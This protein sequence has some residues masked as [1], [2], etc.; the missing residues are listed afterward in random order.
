MGWLEMLAHTH[1]RLTRNVGVYVFS[2]F[3]QSTRHHGDTECKLR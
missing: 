3:R 2:W 1:V